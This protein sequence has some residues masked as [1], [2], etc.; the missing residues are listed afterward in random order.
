MKD[1]LAN[2]INKKFYKTKEL[3]QKKITTIYAADMITDVE[4]S[5][6]LTLI[7]TVYVD[8]AATA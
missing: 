8:S 1:I 6:L 7:D 2:L 3:A 4:F 5:E